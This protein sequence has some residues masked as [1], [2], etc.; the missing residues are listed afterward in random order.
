MATRT[1]KQNI[2]SFLI[3]VERFDNEELLML[4]VTMAHQA[5][6]NDFFSTKAFIDRAD[7]IGSILTS[8]DRESEVA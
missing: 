4:Y 7:K 5:I 2:E 3:F 6:G 8:S 1:S